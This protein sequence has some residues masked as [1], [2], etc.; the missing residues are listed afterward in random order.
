MA[1]PTLQQ[2]A[3]MCPRCDYPGGPGVCP[4]CG[5]SVKA[6]DL[7]YVPRGRRRRS[8]VRRILVRCSVLTLLSGGVYTILSKANWPALLPTNALLAADC[9]YQSERVWATLTQRYTNQQMTK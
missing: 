1:K 8:Q 7:A 5:T 3:G 4:E 9:V 6:E 2:P